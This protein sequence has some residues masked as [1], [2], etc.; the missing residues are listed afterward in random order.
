MVNGMNDEYFINKISH[1]LRN[2]KKK[3]HNLWNFSCPYCGDSKRDKTKARGYIYEN[4]GSLNYKCHNCNES[5]KFSTFLKKNFNDVYQEYLLENFKNKGEDNMGIFTNIFSK[6]GSPKS[7]PQTEEKKENSLL[8]KILDRVDSLPENHLAIE[9]IKSRKIPKEKW[10]LLYYIDDIRKINAIGEKFN[11]KQ[12]DERLLI[13]F[14]SRNGTFLGFTARS[15]TNKTP[16]YFA[17]RL[18][19]NYPFVYGLDRLSYNRPI[20][21]VEGP[22]D[23]LFLPNACAAGTAAFGEL[24]TQL[25]KDKVI[26]VLD[27]QPRNRE[28]LLQYY[29]L[30][31]SGYNVFLWNKDFSYKDINEAVQ[32]GIAPKEIYDNILNNNYNGLELK[33]KL[34]EWSKM[35]G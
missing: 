19:K 26:C 6:F 5:C 9:Y 8:D 13:P 12:A 16:K 4:N 17:V 2:F 27:N 28:I 10:G 20:V 23:S 35:N 31:N 21:V 29:K 25:P 1:N 30:A 11:I 34:A 33:L 15:L 24:L 32:N 18:N 3:G 7:T 14:Y 22:I